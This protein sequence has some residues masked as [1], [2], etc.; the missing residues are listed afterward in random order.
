MASVTKAFLRVILGVV[1]SIGLLFSPGCSKDSPQP[2]ANEY[3]NS[4]ILDT[5]G[6]VYYWNT[7]LPVNADKIKTPDLFFKSLLSTEDRFSWIKENYEELLKSLQGVTKEAGYEF[8]LYRA[9]QTNNNVLAQIL[10]IKPN[11]PAA[12]AGL[13]RGDVIDQINNQ[14]LTQDNYLS[15][16]D[17]I[18]LNH[19][20]TYRAYTASTNSLA[21][22][23][24]ISLSVLEYAENPNFLDKVITVD[25][26]K[27]G[28]YVY[29][30]FSTGTT[31]NSMQYNEEMDAVFARFKS[32][33]ITD[34]ILDLRF[35]SGGAETATIN[36]ASLIAKNV[37][38]TKVFAK[39]QYNSILT[40]Q[41]LNDPQYG[42]EFLTSK[43]KVKSQN[44][45]SQL[46]SGRVYILTSRRSAS[47]SELL[48]NGLKPYMDVFLI[49]DKTVGKNVG[50]ISIYEQNDPKNKWGMQPIV[51]KSFNSL[52]Q[53]NYSTGFIP[54]ISDLD[55]GIQWPLGD[56]RETLLRL[57][58][59]HINGGGRIEKTDGVMGTP[60]GDSFDFKTRNK[61]LIVK[62]P[63]KNH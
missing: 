14:Q 44:I 55:N 45:G 5:M 30:L 49:G 13:L 57:A 4:W 32:T 41:I 33:G 60:L 16:L 62:L 15:L 31:S 36:L 58:L 20:I 42:A 35:N 17:Q 50:S 19:S 18:N 40:S 27:V 43:F 53:S 24:T 1:L 29:N 38:Q 61:E 6:E 52:D 12:N 63:I 59:L 28:Y 54:N 3:V 51:V 8:T 47:A 22:S 37:D 39:R 7:L 10:Y 48:I 46:I 25:N 23:K 26:R 9:S 56:S 2:N 11:S 34:L 21:A